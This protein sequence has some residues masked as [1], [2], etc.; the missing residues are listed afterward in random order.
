MVFK[1]REKRGVL[2]T[3]G[4]FFYPRGG[5]WRAYEYVRLRL[6]RLPGSP[7]YIARGIWV[8]VFV[9]F[10]PFY[11]L[12]F[13]IA[14]LLAVMFRG[15]IIASLLAT[16]FGNPLTYLPI[17]AAS[18]GTG[19]F[20]LGMRRRDFPE[21]TIGDRFWQATVDL[22]YNFKAIFTHAHMKWGSLPAFWDEVFFPWMIGGILPGIVA[23]TIVYM[24]S[25]PVI[26]SYQNRRDR[27]RAEKAA[28]KRG[29]IAK[30][31]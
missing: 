6:H 22:G 30:N 9:T 13:F 31:V 28:Q 18:L 23:A 25:L 16:F 14:A 24:M 4:E 21:S 11:G 3:L 17:A 1:R 20:M 29:K 26:R 15:N 27:I 19:Y 2:R 7:E 5:W 10:T 8:G 12:H